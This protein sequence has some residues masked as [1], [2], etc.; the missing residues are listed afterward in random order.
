MKNI[1]MDFI[2]WVIYETKR[3]YE[4]IIGLMIGIGI[5]ML[6]WNVK[7]MKETESLQEEMNRN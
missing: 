7:N 1:I 4:F 6:L 2:V 3:K 5:G